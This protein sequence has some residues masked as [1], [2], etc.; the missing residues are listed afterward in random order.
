[1]NT[2]EFCRKFEEL[3]EVYTDIKAKDEH[4][5]S[6]EKQLESIKQTISKSGYEVKQ[7]A[8]NVFELVEAETEQVSDGDYTRPYIYEN[9]MTVETGKFYTDGENIWE[10]ILDG[11][12]AGFGDKRYFDIIED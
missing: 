8:D 4:I 1:M 2:L 7:T 11:V 6:L 3:R 9:E 10:A 5:A 12:P